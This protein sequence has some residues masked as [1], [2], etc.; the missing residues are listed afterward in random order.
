[1]QKGENLIKSNDMDSYFGFSGGPA[2][3]KDKSGKIKLLGVWQGGRYRERVLLQE[4]EEDQSSQAIIVENQ[5]V[6]FTKAI[7][8]W[9]MKKIHESFLDP[10][11]SLCI[12][13]DSTHK[14]YCYLENKNQ[15]PPLNLQ[16]KEFFPQSQQ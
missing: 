15:P 14:P 10:S 6:A 9:T 1:M 8:Q 3:S 4:N 7:L 2:Y 11:R 16:S 5:A 12:Q 13:L